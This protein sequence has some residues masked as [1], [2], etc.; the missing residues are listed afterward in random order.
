MP[1]DPPTTLR[2]TC[3]D[4]CTLR[5][6]HQPPLYMYAPHPP[7]LQSLELPLKRGGIKNNEYFYSQKKM[8]LPTEQH[9]EHSE[10]ETEKQ[11]GRRSTCYDETLQYII[12]NKYLV[13]QSKTK[14]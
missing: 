4:N 5:T 7:L 9:A 12:H 6:L 11:S 14:E 8:K 3:T 1:P 2:Y 13:P 10:I